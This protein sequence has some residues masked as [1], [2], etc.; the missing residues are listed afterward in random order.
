MKNSV[1]A[2]VIFL[3]ATTAVHAQQ[4]P[5]RLPPEPYPAL[6]GFAVWPAAEM[7]GFLDTLKTKAA[8]QG[9]VQAIERFGDAGSLKFF[10]ERREPGDYSPEAHGALDDLILV[11][12][13]QARLIV[14][15]TMEGGQRTADGELRGER[16]VG[17][18]TQMLAT[19]DLFFVP[20]G[21]PHHMMVA[22]GQ[23]FYILV[24][25]A[26]ATK[27]ATK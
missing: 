2:A 10:V 1:M 15:G 25:K 18:K 17:G 14:G 7:K 12:D 4:T 5:P 13:G 11:L 20:A 9:G 16:I 22:Q 3:C 21:T 23:H 24:I 26:A 27:A 19:G 8:K 6:N